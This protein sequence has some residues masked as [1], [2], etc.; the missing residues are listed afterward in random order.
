[1][2]YIWSIKYSRSWIGLVKL[3]FK[4]RPVIYFAIIFPLATAIRSSAT[5]FKPFIFFH[6]A[7]SGRSYEGRSLTIFV[8]VLTF[9]KGEAQPPVV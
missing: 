7:R 1:M 6:V 2:E 9:E 3:H 8:E 5:L 4:R